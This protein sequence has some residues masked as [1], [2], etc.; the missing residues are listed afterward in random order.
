MGLASP[1]LLRALSV[2]GLGVRNLWGL[3]T[4]LGAVGSL[5]PLGTDVYFVEK[6]CTTS[7]FRMQDSSVQGQAR[8]FGASGVSL[9]AGISGVSVSCSGYLGPLGSLGSFS[10]TR[11][12]VLCLESFSGWFLCLRDLRGLSLG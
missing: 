12:G 10:E 1:G 7:W 11:W 3:W 5:G 8:A 9:S 6:R 4:E 2:L